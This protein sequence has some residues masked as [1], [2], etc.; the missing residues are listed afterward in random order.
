[1]RL[2]ERKGE[3]RAT[4]NQVLEDL[5]RAL[6]KAGGAD[7]S[8]LLKRE[9]QEWLVQEMLLQ[10]LLTFEFGFTAYATNTYLVAA[11]LASMLGQHRCDE[12][13]V[14]AG[15]PG[16]LRRQADGWLLILFPCMCAC[17]LVCARPAWL[18]QHQQPA[19]TPAVSKK[20]R[21][22]SQLQ[23]PKPTSSRPALPIVVDGEDSQEDDFIR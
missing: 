9:E 12:G 7:S 3:K 17:R 14:L 2:Q 13:G 11:P 20:R 18:L 4:L 8:R 21:S 22:S 16:Y 10:G 19:R 1:M 6:K 5:Q 15:G 23:R